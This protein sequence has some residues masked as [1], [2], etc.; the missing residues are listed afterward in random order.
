[1]NWTR[2]TVYIKKNYQPCNQLRKLDKKTIDSNLATT[3]KYKPFCTW[4]Y[5][6]LEETI[7]LIKIPQWFE[8]LGKKVNKCQLKK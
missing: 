6:P 5:K 3:P 8:T 4:G 2:S 7:P 1:M